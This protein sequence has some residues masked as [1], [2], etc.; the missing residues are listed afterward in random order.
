[1]FIINVIFLEV[2]NVLGIKFGGDRGV[3]YKWIIME[4]RIKNFKFKEASFAF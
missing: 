3:F 4:Q 1:M 2:I